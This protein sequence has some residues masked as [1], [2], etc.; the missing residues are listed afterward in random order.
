M[1]ENKLKNANFVFLKKSHLIKLKLKAIR[2]GVWF[3]ALPRID[4]VLVDLTIKVAGNVR[5]FTLVKSILTVMRKLEGL[6]DNKLLRAVREIGF[7]IAQRLS[8]IAQEWGNGSAKEWN[9]TDRFAR[10]WAVMALNENRLFGGR[11]PSV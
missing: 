10:F 11:S 2:S 4:R 9:S 8:L 3:R 5:S 1:P 7:P 6:L